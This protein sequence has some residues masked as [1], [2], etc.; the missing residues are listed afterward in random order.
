MDFFES[1]NQIFEDLNLRLCFPRNL[2]E[3]RLDYAYVML[4]NVTSIAKLSFIAQNSINPLD[5]SVGE[6]PK[7]DFLVYGIGEREFPNTWK[8]FIITEEECKK[9]MSPNRRLLYTL[10]LDLPRK[11]ET[12]LRL[13]YFKNFDSKVTYDDE[14]FHLR[15][16]YFNENIYREILRLLLQESILK[17]KTAALIGRYLKIIKRYFGDLESC[18][19][20]LSVSFILH[21]LYKECNDSQIVKDV[22]TMFD[23]KKW[24][25]YSNDCNPG[26][27]DYFLHH[28]RNSGYNVWGKYPCEDLINGCVMLEKYSF[29]AVLL[30]YINAPL[31]MEEDYEKLINWGGNPI[32]RI[33]TMD[34]GQPVREGWM[35]KRR[36]FLAIQILYLYDLPHD[37][38]DQALRLL[39]RAIPDTFLTFSEWMSAFGNQREPYI[40][41]DIDEFYSYIVEEEISIRTPRSLRQYCRV[42]IRK[43]LYDCQQLPNGIEKLDD[44]DPKSKAY[45]RLE[46]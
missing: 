3:E 37:D 6:S 17:F 42:A 19:Y 29:V 18:L 43:S 35:N 12:R 11:L 40:L 30:K 26:I 7:K 5:L 28:A 23:F 16:I 36:A 45:L 2:H 21:V 4:N 32:F 25:Y 33:N 22:L 20:D 38:G 10:H 8:N 27:L 31:F 1:L 9:I 44:L 34:K 15:D 14:S 39:W 24:I 13:V 46:N 41:G